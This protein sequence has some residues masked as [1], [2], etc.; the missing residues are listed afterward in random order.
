MQL[1]WI[2]LATFASEDLA[3]VAAGALVASRRMTL[4]DATL[5]SATGIFAGDMLLFLVGR[6]AWH[7]KL[8]ARLVR[9][10]VPQAKLDQASDWINNQGLSVVLLSRFTP[11]LR[12]PTYVA[13]GLLGGRTLAF[14][15]YFLL[16]A[17]LWTPLL[18]AGSAFLGEKILTRFGPAALVSLGGV[19]IA[20]Q[21]FRNFERRRRIFGFFKRKIAWE[22]WPAWAAYLPLLPYLTY[23]AIRHRSMTLFTAANPGIETGGFAGES[24]SRILTHLVSKAPPGAVAGF[25]VVRNAEEVLAVVE[26]LQF[27]A[28]L[29]PDVGERGAGV[30]VVRSIEQVREYFENAPDGDRIILQRYVPGVEFGVYYVRYPDEARG[31]VASITR[32][33]FPRVTGDGVRTLGELILSD[34]RAVCMADAYLASCKLSMDAVPAMGASVQLVELGSHCRGSVFLDGSDL[35]TDVLNEA[36]DRV[37]QAHPGFY[38][39]RFDIRAASERDFQ[40]G[41][42]Q[43]IELNGVSAEPAH[44]YDPAVS[45]VEAYRTMMWQWR[46]AF[47]IGAIN[48]A[49]GFAPMTVREFIWAIRAHTT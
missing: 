6:L 43:V 8:L 33:L 4:F 25:R 29:K 7:S 20:W 44:I 11:G 10:W 39:G 16:A 49:A 12:L 47:E 21:T 45:L 19:V 36:V 23:L 27:P 35:M 41:K 1:V 13:S 28:V 32:K 18:V 2:A 17:L 24:K 14:T 34:S 48:R 5:A 26:G 9:R 30:A 15:G 31:R 42:F 37:A 3:L 22:F 46:T 40:E 38:I